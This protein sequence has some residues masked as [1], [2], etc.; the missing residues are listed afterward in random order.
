[1]VLKLLMTPVV[2]NAMPPRAPVH[3]R[4]LKYV[5]HSTAFRSAG[6]MLC[7]PQPARTRVGG[8][9]LA[10]PGRGGTGVTAYTDLILGGRTPR[11]YWYGGLVGDVT[12]SCAAKPESMGR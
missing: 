3:G 1:M 6:F 4:R 9:G 10:V 12:A 5:T 7:S 8:H 2:L 11:K